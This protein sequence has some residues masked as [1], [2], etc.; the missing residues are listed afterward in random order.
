MSIVFQLDQFG[1][2]RNEHLPR[3]SRKL[4]LFA[5]INRSCRIEASLHGLSSITLPAQR[6]NYTSREQKTILQT[7]S[8]S[9]RYILEFVA[10]HGA[11]QKPS[12]APDRTRR[13]L[14]P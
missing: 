8:H 5:E 1:K 11:G 4:F 10:H 6:G 7:V 3:D 2:Y 9:H 14:V 12:A 13:L